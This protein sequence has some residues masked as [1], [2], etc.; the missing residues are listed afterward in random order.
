MNDE[1]KIFLAKIGRQIIDRQM[2][3]YVLYLPEKIFDWLVE[4][5]KEDAD[6]Q[7]EEIVKKNFIDMRNPGKH[8]KSMGLFIYKHYGPEV[9]SFSRNDFIEIQVDEATKEIL[10]C[11]FISSKV[12]TMPV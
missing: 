5:L 9:F 3:F 10:S 4:R 7:T 1:G 2:H 12:E 11:K 6:V 8:F